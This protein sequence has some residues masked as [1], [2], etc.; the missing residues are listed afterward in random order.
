M[1]LI[2][3]YPLLIF[4]ILCILYSQSAHSQPLS[5]QECY[6]IATENYPLSKQR[7]LITKSRDYSVDNASKGYYPQIQLIGQATYQSDVTSLPIELPGMNIPSL[8]KDQYRFYVDITQ[9]IYEGGVIKQQK[10]VLKD[11]SEMETQKL[12]VELYKLRERVLQLYFGI[13]ILDEQIKITNLSIVDLEE[14]Q[15]KTKAS[16]QNGLVLSSQLDVLLVEIL[17]IKQKLTELN[18]AREGYLAMLGLFINRVLDKNSQ[19]LMPQTILLTNEIIRPEIK[20]FDLQ[21]RSLQTQIKLITARNRPKLS[22]FVQTGY[23]RPALNMLDNEFKSYYS[24]G[25]RLNVPITGYYTLKNDRALIEQN[26]ST[27]ELQKSTYLFNTQYTLTQQN[28]ELT[29]YKELL[30]SDDEIIQLRTSIKKNAS[31]QLENGIIT[32]SEYVHEAMAEALARQN[33][34]LHQLQMLMTQY[35][36][37]NT[38]GH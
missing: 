22:L 12:E 11:Q 17:K 23:G 1:I 38:T 27:I 13:L 10:Q 34:S 19:L 18:S 37:L 28:T 32:S 15:S 8:S 25:I 5:L 21:Q 2:K 24:G 16:V 26:Q 31:T 30:S 7:E 14:M 20:V 36:Y 35:S 6:K 29:K 33:K 9:P 3:R 4:A